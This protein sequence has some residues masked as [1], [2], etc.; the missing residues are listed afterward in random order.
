MPRTFQ[1]TERADFT[2]ANINKETGVISGVRVLNPVSKN[3]RDYSPQA[4][5]D[6]IGLAEGARVFDQHSSTSPGSR[7]SGDMLGML[8]NVREVR[9]GATADL[10]V[11]AK[12][13]WLLEDAKRMPESIMLSI[14]AKGRGRIQP[15]NGRLLVESVSKLNSV[16]LVPIGGTTTSLFESDQEDEQVDLS[17]LT[18]AE[19]REN[20][21]DM[22]GQIEEAAAKIATADSGKDGQITKLS[23]QL[24]ESVDQLAVSKKKLDELSVKEAIAQRKE[25]VAKALE[26]SELP[27]TAITDDFKALLESFS[28]D[29]EVS[30]H[31]EDRKKLVEG[32][33]PLTGGVRSLG[34]SGKKGEKAPEVKDFVESLRD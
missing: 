18:L 27:E 12:A 1:L 5:K 10:Q 25:A 6:V 8:R 33:E 23:Q 24:K 32:I 17:K 9:N 16:D 30:K 3:K 20:C 31:I 28:D 19:L 13:P 22:V 29:A 14:N 7:K 2:G 34:D 26:E 21:P 11:S 4:V 15:G